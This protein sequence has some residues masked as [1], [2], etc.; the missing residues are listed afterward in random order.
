MRLAPC[1]VALAVTAIALAGCGGDD[2]GD[3][4]GTATDRDPSAAERGEP[5]LIKTQVR[6]AR[7]G[8]AGGEV[9]RGSRIGDSAFC[10]GGKFSDRHGEPPLGLVVKTFRCPDGRLTVTFNP[11]QDSLN[12]SSAW[13]VVSG[14][15][16]FEG[17]RLRGEGQ[18]KA[19]FSK[20]DTSKGRETFTG[21]VAP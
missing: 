10:P 5:I 11:T 18:M 4:A 9:L 3:E 2:G 16:R 14:T 8:G 19:R 1:V 12:Q 7:G 6:V 13:S 21:T 20:A 17:L 15:G